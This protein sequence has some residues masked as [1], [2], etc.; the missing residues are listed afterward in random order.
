MDEKINL[1]D[2]IS[3]LRSSVP[4]ISFVHFTDDQDFIIASSDRASL[5]REFFSD[6]LEN[7]ESVVRQ[8]DGYYEGG[9]SIKI[10]EKRIGALYF[11]AALTVGS[12]SQ[13]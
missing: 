8:K 3:E 11:E 13:Q 2:V 6:I 5:G 12:S 7:D 4:E 9:F 1:D 10:G